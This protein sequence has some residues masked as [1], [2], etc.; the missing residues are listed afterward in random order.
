MPRRSE[1]RRAA[2]HAGCRSR[3]TRLSVALAV[4]ALFASPANAI[5]GD[6]LR[7]RV[8]AGVTSDSN[9]FRLPDSVTFPNGTSRS[10]LLSYLSAGLDFD[11]DWSAQRF[12][13]A[14]ILRDTRYTENPRLDGFDWSAL[15][16]WTL[17]EGDQNSLG[18]DLSRSRATLGFADARVLGR[19]VVDTTS[20]SVRG[21]L[22]VVPRWSA[23]AAVG[24]L[25]TANEPASRSVLDYEQTFVE[26][27]ARYDFRT[28]S[29][30]DFVWRHSDVDFVNG[31][32][33]GFDNGYSQDD[34]GLRLVWRVTEVTLLS[35]RVGLQ[36]RDYADARR[37]RFTGPGV[38]LNADWR[39]RGGLQVVTT[40]RSELSAP[41]EINAS[42]AR[43]NAVS[44]T[45]SWLATGKTT[46]RAGV[47]LMRR[48]FRGD[49]TGGS[50]VAQRRDLMTALTG[51]IS[52]QVWRTLEL[53]ADLR[54]D[55]RDSN[56]DSFDYF[57]RIF[58]LRAGMVF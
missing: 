56:V 35:G 2:G 5:D 30:V 4:A 29:I 53:G 46:L 38:S 27:G 39:P 7:A 16:G 24:W 31:N 54:L 42:Y 10:E 6:I 9:L 33:L 44:T 58:T 50:N 36:V 23:I 41:A 49:G 22:E 18:I 25:S 26:T 52:I 15:L 57:T 17:L 32:S 51:A 43:I 55:R 34:I 12:R 3:T 21:A 14:F 1:H 20:L 48:D 8:S 37:D 40:L 19:P 28:G 13:A 47:D 11:R 45:A